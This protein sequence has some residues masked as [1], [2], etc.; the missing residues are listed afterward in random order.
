[1]RVIL[2]LLKFI[3]GAA[4]LIAPTML[5]LYFLFDPDLPP[6]DQDAREDISGS[7]TGDFIKLS[8]GV[9]YYQ[10]HGDP[11]GDMIVLVHGFMVPSFVFSSLTQTLA[12]AGFRVL[13]YDQ[14]GRGFS[15]RPDTDYDAEL[16]DR[17]LTEL[18]GALEVHQPVHM[19]G[20]SMGGA[21]ATVF[22]AH[23]P[24][25]IQTLTLIAPAGMAPDGGNGSTILT[26]VLLSPGVGDWMIR[27]FGPTLAAKRAESG[28]SKA[29]DPVD[30]G[31]RFLAQ[32]KYDGFYESLLSILRFYPMDG[33]AKPSFKDVGN[34]DIPV[35]LIWGEEDTQEPLNSAQA[36][37]TAIPHAKLSAYA[38]FGH[39]ITYAGVHTYSPALLSFFAENTDQG[40]AIESEPAQAPEE[41][42]QTANSNGAP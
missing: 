20:Y 28:F 36:I 4:I 37:Q 9:T 39:E 31:K 26:R 10:W 18:L 11:D 1:M 34:L 5:A 40:T 3:G 29:P 38:R 35:L 7:Q 30:M 42:P 21:L 27:V 24:E 8:D 13:T 12:Q 23:H 2:T 41:S 22:T 25:H 14:F 15:D 19:L 32:T 6:L 16:L 17:Q 33:S